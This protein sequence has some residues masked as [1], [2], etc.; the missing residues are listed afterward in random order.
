MNEIGQKNQAQF[1]L[2][3]YYFF[4]RFEMNVFENETT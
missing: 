2:G 4:Y 3:K 1:Q